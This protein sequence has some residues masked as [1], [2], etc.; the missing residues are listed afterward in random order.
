[1]NTNPSK[2]LTIVLVLLLSSIA[3][4]AKPAESWNHTIPDR[5]NVIAMLNDTVYV[6]SEDGLI[7][8]YG[9]NG[10]MLWSYQTGG[11]VK[12][13]HA[14]EYGILAGSVDGFLYLLDNNG[15]LVWMK[16]VPSYIGY[17]DAVDS[18]NET[19]V[20][21]SIDGSVYTF[22]ANGVFQWHFKTDSY[23]LST[24]IV[25]GKIIVV[26]DKKIYFLNDSGESV[27][28]YDTGSYIT[29]EYIS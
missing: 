12:A 13:L 26:S 23:V 7:Y 20:A 21:G 17:K 9:K 3:S 2:F 8:A 15:I 1:V 14:S 27:Y 18:S 28:N 4:A 16:R 5:V 25:D 29:S 22:D 11:A 19:V 10:R 6:C 24:R